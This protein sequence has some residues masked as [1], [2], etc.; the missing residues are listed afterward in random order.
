MERMAGKLVATSLRDLE[1]QISALSPAEKAEVVRKL[2]LE[3]VNTWPGIEKIPGVM[4]GSACVVRT[5]ISV[6]MLVNYRRLSMSEARIL[7]AYPVLRATDLANAW[8]YADAHQ[9]EIE[10][11]IRENEMA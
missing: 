4:G 10:R 3:V 5:R 6:W 8:A 9:D 7:D 2:A 1:D 11:D